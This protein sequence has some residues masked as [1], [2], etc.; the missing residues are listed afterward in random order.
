MICQPGTHRCVMGGV[1][2]RCNT[3][4]SAWQQIDDCG[5]MN[6]CD[7]DEGECND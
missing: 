4:G 3:G 7:A 5:K 2:Q 6:Q 1:L